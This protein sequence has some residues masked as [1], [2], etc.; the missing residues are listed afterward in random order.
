MDLRELRSFVEVSRLSSIT[1]AAKVLHIAQPAITRQ[2]RK[3]EQE[4]GVELLLRSSRGVKLTAAGTA[5]LQKAEDLLRRAGQLKEELLK[6]EHLL[7]GH[8]AIAVP[9]TTGAMVVPALLA[10]MRRDHPGI[11]IHVMEGVNV[12]LLDWVLAG[13]ADLALLHDPPGLVTL[14]SQPL[15]KEPL[16]LVSPPGAGRGGQLRIRDLDEVPLILPA[17]PISFAFWWNRPRRPLA[18]ACGLCWRLMGSP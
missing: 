11:S 5:L 10:R 3:L 6:A 2:L 17:R 18:S 8:V 15:V 9:P 13:R 14:R 1:G 16:Y 4:L 12:T 7:A